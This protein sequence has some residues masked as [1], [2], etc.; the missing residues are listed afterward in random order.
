MGI[1]QGSILVS[2]LFSSNINNAADVRQ[3]INL[4]AENNSIL[5][6]PPSIPSVMLNLQHDFDNVQHAFADLHLLLNSKKTMYFNRKVP[7]S[8]PKVVTL[9][10]LEL[11]QVTTYKYVSG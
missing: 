6:W 2:T 3:V 5:E 10:G 7:R 11:E 9:E 4:Y 1:L 8:L